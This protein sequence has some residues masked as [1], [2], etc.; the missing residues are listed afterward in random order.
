[1]QVFLQLGGGAQCVE[2]VVTAGQGFV[3]EQQVDATVAGLA[4]LGRRAVAATFLA[5]HQMV[6]RSMLHQPAAQL[7]GGQRKFRHF[8]NR[9]E[10]LGNGFQ[11]DN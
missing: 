3:V 10:V 7:A 9:N 5:G 2:G 8:G 6:A 1:M 4:K 11:T